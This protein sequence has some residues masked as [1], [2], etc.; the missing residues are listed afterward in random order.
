MSSS[1]P[2]R[3]QAAANMAVVRSAD[4]RV[5]V[6]FCDEMAAR[7][8]IPGDLVPFQHDYRCLRAKRRALLGAAAECVAQAAQGVVVPMAVGAR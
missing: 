2:E 4:Q 8:E 6:P 5:F 3:H 1:K 7:S